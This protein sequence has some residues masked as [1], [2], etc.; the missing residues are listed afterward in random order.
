MEPGRRGA[1]K[2]SATVM[3]AI[4]KDH[5][6]LMLLKTIHLE[7]IKKKKEPVYFGG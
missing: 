7:C 5:N 6:T 2:G 4:A 1:P 3:F